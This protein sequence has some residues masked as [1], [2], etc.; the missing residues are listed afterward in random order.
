MSGLI[1]ITGAN[2][3]IA[4]L[5]RPL[6]KDYDVILVSRRSLKNLSK[7][8]TNIICSDI[9]KN[10]WWEG[11][12]KYKPFDQ[13]LHLA[14]IVKKNVDSDLISKSHIQF[15][16][17]A[18]LNSNHVTYPLTAYL[19]DENRQHDSYVEIK[20]IVAKNVLLYDNIFLPI[21]HPVIDYGDGLNRMI[22]LENKIPF[23]NIFCCFNSTIKRVESEFLGKKI[24]LI[25][26]F[27]FIDIYSHKKQISELFAIPGRRD[28][29]L[30][31]L[32]LKKILHI[33][34]FI[35]SIEIL[36]KGRASNRDKII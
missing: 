31:S 32:L 9:E 5:I 23:F 28:F 14:E 36:I 10:N 11:V 35:H 1:L 16:K 34:S 6:F 8:E 30:L 13:V 26:R 4:T 22:K 27:G 7:N 3:S 2:G 15:L 17:W 33:F 29:Y 19:Y 20:K 12:K 18:C 24:I 21:I 25:D